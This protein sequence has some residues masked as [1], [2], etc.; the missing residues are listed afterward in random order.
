MIGTHRLIDLA[1]LCPLTSFPDSGRFGASGVSSPDYRCDLDIIGIDEIFG[2]VWFG[3]VGIAHRCIYL[4]QSVYLGMRSVGK[5]R[6]RRV[7]AHIL[8]IG[9]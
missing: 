2:S 5:G 1:K 7:M 4:Q 8:H 6:Y 3:I 9:R